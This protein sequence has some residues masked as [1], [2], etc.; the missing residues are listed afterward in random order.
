MPNLVFAVVI[1]LQMLH[2]ETI[3]RR[4]DS[5]EVESMTDLEENMHIVLEHLRNVHPYYL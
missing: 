4:T 2:V 1:R 3:V 5:T